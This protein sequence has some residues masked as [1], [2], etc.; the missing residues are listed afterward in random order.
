[1]VINQLVQGSSTTSIV[2][3][4]D[5]QAVSLAH[6]KYNSRSSKYKP[7]TCFDFT[8]K[9]GKYAHNTWRNMDWYMDWSAEMLRNQESIIYWF[10]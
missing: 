9:I 2:K 7:I 10:F 3:A 1:M 8:F 4:L 5:T 6:M